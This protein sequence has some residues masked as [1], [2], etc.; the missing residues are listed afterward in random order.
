MLDELD[1]TKEVANIE[2]FR[3]FLKVNGLE[4]VAYAPEPY[5]SI[6]GKKVFKRLYI[7][8]ILNECYNYSS[9]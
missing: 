7:F 8:L 4:D 9:E 2:N 6:S 5:A 1:F 3:S